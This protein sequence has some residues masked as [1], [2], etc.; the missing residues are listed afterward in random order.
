MYNLFKCTF[1]SIDQSEVIDFEKRVRQLNAGLV[2]MLYKI[3]HRRQN[4][5]VETAA[6]DK[7][8]S[9][10]TSYREKVNKQV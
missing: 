5:I 7:K 3:I 10:G 2:Q 8:K 1:T 9:L 6:N 4:H